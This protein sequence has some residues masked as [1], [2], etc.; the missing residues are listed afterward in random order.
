MKILLTLAFALAALAQD[1]PAPAP[2]G[3]AKAADATQADAAKPAD[4]KPA[5]TAAPAA[6]ASPVPTGEKWV[7]GFIELGYRWRTDV[8]GSK[9]TYRSI[10][11]LGSGLKLIGTEFTVI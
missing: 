7:T 6:A 3:D 10:V 11:N 8:G 2:S 1:A 5:D 4:A 9:E